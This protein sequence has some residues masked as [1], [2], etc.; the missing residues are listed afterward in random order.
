MCYMG[1]LHGEACF[2]KIY[3]PM[4]FVLMMSASKKNYLNLSKLLR[5]QE[6][7]K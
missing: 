7:Y 6:V 1:K 5:T 3:Y 2:C 4:I